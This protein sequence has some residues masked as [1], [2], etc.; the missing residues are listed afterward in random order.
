MGR[1]ISPKNVEGYV[2]RDEAQKKTKSTVDSRF[3]TIPFT[4]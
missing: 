1:E 4:F 2:F 3:K